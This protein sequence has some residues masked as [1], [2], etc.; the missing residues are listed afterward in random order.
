MSAD[1]IALAVAVVGVAGTP[2]APVFTQRLAMR[3]RQQELDAQHQLRLEEREDGQRRAALRDRRETYVTLNA[4][5]RSFRRAM[6]NHAL[7]FT[8]ETR[9]EL[10]RARQV[11]DRQHAEG[12]LITTHPVM[13]AAR[14]VSIRL[15][16]AYDH[17][18]GLSARDPD[19][20]RAKEQRRIAGGSGRA[21]SRRGSAS[22]HGDAGGTRR[23]EVEV[24]RCP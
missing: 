23:V 17:I 4:A 13:E 8:E 2:A 9:A 21:P 15:S 20:E 11:F 18:R 10:E 19:G 22:P 6:R 7:E 12:Q 3:A 1:I 14:V 24:P 16:D 5:I